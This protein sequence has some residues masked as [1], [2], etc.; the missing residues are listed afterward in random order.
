MCLWSHELIVVR[1]VRLNKSGFDG[2]K[3]FVQS[4]LRKMVTRKK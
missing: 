3:R 4:H 1:Q 2:E